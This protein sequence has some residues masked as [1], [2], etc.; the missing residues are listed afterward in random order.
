MQAQPYSYKYAVLRYVKDAKRNVSIPVGVALWSERAQWVGLRFVSQ[1]ERLATISGEDYAFIRLVDHKI[2]NWL[3]GGNLPYD[4]ERL[5]PV[6]DRWWQHLQKI[7]IHKVRIAEPQAIECCDPDSEL[8]IIFRS[9]VDSR[10]FVN[11]GSSSASPRRLAG[12]VPY[13]LSPVEPVFLAPSPG[14]QRQFWNVFEGNG[15]AATGVGGYAT[16]G[17]NTGAGVASG[18]LPGGLS[19]GSVEDNGM[20]LDGFGGYAT[21]TVYVCTGITSNS[22]PR[23]L[24]SGPLEDNGMSVGKFGGY[25]TNASG[26]GSSISTRAVASGSLED[27][28]VWVTSSFSHATAPPIVYI[29]DAPNIVPVT[30]RPLVSSAL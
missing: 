22:S 20:W 14:E 3:K 6:S 28:G 30:E 4:E 25:A 11:V 26:V 24:N 29:D 10:L 27:N 19:G 13:N 21:M 8:E 12:S 18:S 16:M 15:I 1:G 5:S 23:A 2:E 7:L 9:V 17:P